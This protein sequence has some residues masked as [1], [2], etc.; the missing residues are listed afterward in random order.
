MSIHGES[1][2]AIIPPD[3]HGVPVAIEVVVRPR[4]TGDKRAHIVRR[5]ARGWE[6]ERVARTSLA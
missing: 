4:D 1:H 6:V 3:L 2:H 5:T